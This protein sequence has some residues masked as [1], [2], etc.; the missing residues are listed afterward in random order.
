MWEQV[1]LCGLFPCLS[2]G[3]NQFFKWAVTWELS[4]RQLVLDSVVE[5]AHALQTESWQRRPI[6]ILCGFSPV[7]G[8]D[9]HL[10]ICALEIV[11]GTE[12][13]GKTPAWPQSWLFRPWSRGRLNISP[14]WPDIHSRSLRN[15]HVYQT[16]RA[17]ITTQSATGRDAVSLLRPAD[18]MWLYVD[19][20]CSSQTSHHPDPRFYTPICFPA[21]K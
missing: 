9:P 11:W 1:L 6:K 14:T 15:S 5:S 8:L 18:N 20:F 4:Q 21:S 3:C 16:K 17:N 2:A 10:F 7:T 13:P 12:I 19:I